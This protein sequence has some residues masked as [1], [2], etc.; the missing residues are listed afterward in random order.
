M[1]LINQQYEEHSL[2]TNDERSRFRHDAA[3]LAE[4]QVEGRKVAGRPHVVC[5]AWFAMA[6]PGDAGMNIIISLLR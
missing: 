5:R 6:K 2:L 3:V 4:W 1:G